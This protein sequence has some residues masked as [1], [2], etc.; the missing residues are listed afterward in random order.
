MT[1]IKPVHL[2]EEDAEVSNLHKVL[3]FL[4]VHQPGISVNDIKSLQDQLAP[5][6]RD[7]RFGQAT[8]RVVGIWQNLLKQRADLPK[9]LK[10]RVSLLPIGRTGEG[11]GDVDEV[12][13]EALNWLLRKMGALH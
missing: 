12:T 13:A 10:E 7:E 4:I 2:G 11:T 5:D 3:L 6:V 1:P 8:A 9:E